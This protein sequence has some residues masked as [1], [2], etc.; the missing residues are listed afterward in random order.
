MTPFSF[1]LQNYLLVAMGLTA[2][3][4]ACGPQDADSDGF[5]AQEDCDDGNAN[6]HPLAQEICDQI[7]NNCDG[8]VDEDASNRT[9]WYADSDGD[10]FGDPSESKLACQTPDGFVA[11]SEDCAPANSE[12][13]PDATEKAGDGV[14]ND[15]DGMTDEMTCPESIVPT[16]AKAIQDSNGETSF[17]FCQQLPELGSCP[18]PAEVQPTALIEQTVGKA[19]SSWTKNANRYRGRW[20]AGESVCGPDDSHPEKCCYVFSAD[21]TID[22]SFDP[23]AL[24]GLL[25]GAPLDHL[26]GDRSIGVISEEYQEPVPGR[27]LSVNGAARL[28]TQ[29]DSTQWLKSIPLDLPSLSPTQRQQLADR[30]L[31]AALYEH[32]SVASFARFTLEL[33]ALGAPPEL[34][35]S[36]TRAQADEV[37]HARD[38]FSIASELSGRPLSAGPLDLTGILTHKTNVEHVLVETILEG[39]INE[40][41]AAAEAS[42]L[43]EQACSLPIQRIQKRIAKDES[44]HAAL[45][46]KTVRWILIN[47]PELNALAK[48]TFDSALQTQR[49]PRVPAVIPDDAW[50]APFGCMPSAKKED[51]R[52]EIWECVI[53]PCAAQ[54]LASKA[55]NPTRKSA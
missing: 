42:W 4:Q 26:S 39:C 8:V 51:L 25:G 49:A 28:A 31:E 34:L 35:L 23:D 55:S 41:I 14:D 17:R 52:R 46:W 32:A 37:V 44:R 24:I 29:S 48:Q 50:M 30:W 33:M 11:A 45:G 20:I 5:N 1:R 38:C 43:S 13:H 3:L 22:V 18:S 6:I 36:A 10:N 15:C 21:E 2:P 16:N 7:D 12:V 19:P 54:L 27:P 47:H 53:Q 40:T 9:T